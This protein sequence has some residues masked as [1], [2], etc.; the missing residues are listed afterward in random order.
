MGQRT[1]EQPRQGKVAPQD[2]QHD[3]GRMA[4]GRE[5]LKIFTVYR[6]VVGVRRDDRRRKGH[7]MYMQHGRRIVQAS[8]LE[9]EIMSRETKA[10]IDIGFVLG[11]LEL[12]R[13][14]N[15]RHGRVGR[16]R[17]FICPAERRRRS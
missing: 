11:R 10:H 15:Q 1:A 2:M 3:D 14:L 6:V 8:L 5:R 16:R 17:R 13:A 4:P 12:D 7:G 9:S